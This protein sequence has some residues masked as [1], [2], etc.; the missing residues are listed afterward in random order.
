MTMP[1]FHELFNKVLAALDEGSEFHRK[2]LRVVVAEKLGLSEDELNET[3]SGGGKRIYS[4]IHWAT[5]Y[6]VQAGAINRPKRGYLEITEFGRQLLKENPNG[7]ALEDVRNTP[8]VLAWTERSIAKR[9]ARNTDDGQDISLDEQFGNDGSPLEN[10][11]S[12]FSV[13]RSA[14][15]GELLE[16]IRNESPDF[17]EHL[18]LELLHKMGY[19]AKPADIEHIGG[20][21]DEGVDGVIHHD[22]LGLD[23]IYI[24]AKRYK[25]DSTIG[26]P[27]IQSF[28]GALSG[29]KAT[30]GVFL[31]TTKF[32][33][34]AKDYV[35]NLTGFTVVLIDGNRLA[36]LMIEHKVGVAIE[37]TFELLSIDE[38]FFGEEF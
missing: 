5:E 3:M 2:E 23:K 19:G 11:E 12:A 31:A 29:K 21:G 1:K 16:R 13:M 6:L 9:E 35:E 10:I 37:D 26:R 27:A 22:Q 33:K 34:D 20:S 38:N 24:Q 17:F 15:A 4:R 14:L 36:D 7:I 32:S 28:V 25:D 18:V 30:R 8:G